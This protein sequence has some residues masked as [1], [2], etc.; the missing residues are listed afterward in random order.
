MANSTSKNGLLIVLIV[1]L[2]A[3]TGL[4]T[5]QYFKTVAQDTALTKL[6]NEKTRLLTE[7]D[8]LQED[9]QKLLND[10]NDIKTDNSNLQEQINSQKSQIENYLE[11]IKGL[12][13]NSKELAYYKKKIK[14]LQL[15]RDAF[16][17]QID[18]LTKANKELAT[19]NAA[20]QSDLE[21]KKGENNVL[22]DKV[23]KAAKIKGVNISIQA[24]NKK[25]KPQKK[26]KRV[27][28]MKLCITL[29]DNEIAK[30]GQREVYF[31]IIDASG[32]VLH[33]SN[34]DVF[35][36][37]GTQLGYSSKVT[38]DYQNKL[39]QACSSYICAEQTIKTGTYDVEAYTDGEKIGQS[40]ITLE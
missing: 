28:E 16:I 25:G 34:N 6:N 11:K 9:Y 1:L 17:A 31:R 32:A 2:L 4:Y 8:S 5:Y 40:Q 7:K 15:N 33:N 3:V 38:V 18:S 10:F 12:S 39:T 37:N 22:S 35:S 36:F 29:V 27:T 13:K 14:E 26:G 23:S 19:Q 24:F 20:F 30:A 21:Q